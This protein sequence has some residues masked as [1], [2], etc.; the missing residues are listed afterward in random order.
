VSGSGGVAFSGLIAPTLLID[1][2]DVAALLERAGTDRLR[3][4]ELRDANFATEGFGGS[5][6]SGPLPAYLGGTGVSASTAMS[7]LLATG[8]GADSGALRFDSGLKWV[9]GVLDVSGEVEIGGGG[10][11]GGVD[12]R[13]LLDGEGRPSLACGD[14]PQVDLSDYALGVP[15]VASIREPRPGFSD[16]NVE[17]EYEASGD[18]RALF[19]SVYGAGAAPRLEADVASGAGAIFSERLSVGPGIGTRLVEGLDPMTRY[20]VMCT[21]LDARGNLSAARAL[22]VRTTGLGAP[23]ASVGS[24][25]TSPARLS[26]VASSA[27]KASPMLLVAGLLTSRTPAMTASDVESRVALFHAESIPENVARNIAVSFSRAHDPARSFAPEPV[28]EGG[29]YHPF[30]YYRDAEGNVSLEY[31]P[32][33]YNPDVTAPSFYLSPLAKSYTET[34]MRVEC[35]LSDAVGV[36]RARAFAALLPS[37]PPSAADVMSRGQALSVLAGPPDAS[38]YLAQ[39][40]SAVS[41]G[42]GPANSG[43]QSAVLS[44]AAESILVTCVFELPPA[45]TGFQMGFKSFGASDA[46]GSSAGEY[47]SGAPSGAFVKATMR[48]VRSEKKV[49]FRAENLGTTAV[50][51]SGTADSPSWYPGTTVAHIRAFGA[52]MSISS[53][54]VETSATAAVTEYHSSGS[55]R[56]LEHT[57]KYRIYVA[58][59]D[60]AGNVGPVAVV[61][62]RTEDSTPPRITSLSAAVAP[63]TSNVTASAVA[64]DDG[65]AASITAIHLLCTPVSGAYT[66]EQVASTAT[67]RFFSATTATA[68]FS[69]VPAYLPS[70]VY[71]VCADNAAEFGSPANLLSQV[72]AADVPVPQVTGASFHQIAARNISVASGARFDPRANPTRIGIFV[73]RSPDGQIDEASMSNL[74]FESDHGSF[75]SFP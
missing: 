55:A 37:S 39:T 29:T 26:F 47:S 60:A 5:K 50:F 3:T 35:G 43:V 24:V 15:P 8:D 45:A 73:V 51:V 7:G 72:A 40:S 19:V 71:A 14:A 1:G 17:V 66:P 70:H 12:A 16:S 59:E 30:A 4:G 49:Y 56:P 48:F 54:R 6:L 53:F 27:P 2:Q 20:V 34:E 58:A 38:Y 33:T 22:D 44:D 52:P 65:P 25:A 74:V 61:D 57:A 41:D 21:A 68:T 11:G 62:A 13:V 28:R 31:G 64:A 63:G 75:Q 18:V 36:V 69:N 10:S 9:S 67:A 23:V 42:V 32:A 46:N